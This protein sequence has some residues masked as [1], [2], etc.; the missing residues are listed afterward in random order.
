[1]VRIENEFGF[2]V[3]VLADSYVR[4]PKHLNSAGYVRLVT[5]LVI[6][7]R[8]VLAELNTHRLFSRNSAS[9]RAIPIEKMIQRVLDNPFIPNR[10]PRTH[11]GMQASEWVN[12]EDVEYPIWK[13]VWLMARDSAIAI[14]RLMNSLGISKQLANR[15]LEPFVMHEV[16]ITASEWENFLSLRTHRDAQDQIRISAEMILEALNTSVPQE[17]LPGQWHMPFGDDFD[18]EHLDVIANEFGAVSADELR[19]SITVARCARTSYQTFDGSRHNYTADLSLFNS[20][21]DQGHWS[22]FEHVA[23]AMTP[24]EYEAYAH[25]FPDGKEY[26]W[27]GNFRGFVQLRKLYAIKIENRPEPR[28]RV[29]EL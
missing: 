28:L 17:L 27:C 29:L 19:R 21:R 23:R 3:Q 2:V 25:T 18:L 9:S 20:L 26:G 13:Y 8:I 14:V 7:P 24:K 4:V 5:I 12:T 6:L 16:I 11:K 15:L 22:P 1:M 10:F